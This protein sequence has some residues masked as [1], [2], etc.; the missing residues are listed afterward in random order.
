MRERMTYRVEPE[1]TRLEASH[2]THQRIR[3]V[4]TACHLLPRFIR[5]PLLSRRLPFDQCVD[6]PDGLVLVDHIRVHG[7]LE[8]RVHVQLI[9]PAGTMAQ[10]V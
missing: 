4:A 9:A 5:M 6:F 10:E 1:V 7:A 3:L 8:Q 2:T